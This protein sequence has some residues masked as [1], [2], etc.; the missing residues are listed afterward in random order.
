[1][2]LQT[3]LEV[4]APAAGVIV[5]LLVPDGDAV[6][7]GMDIFK[8]QVGGKLHFAAL[9]ASILNLQVTQHVTLRR[10]YCISPSKRPLVL[11]W[12]F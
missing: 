9:H 6:T 2:R 1:M 5:E 8:M 7:A 10:K 11:Y 4:K 12:E 3:A